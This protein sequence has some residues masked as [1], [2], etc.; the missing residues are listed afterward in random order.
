MD[1]SNKIASSNLSCF[2]L[3]YLR[4]TFTLYELRKLLS[5]TLLGFLSG[6]LLI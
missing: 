2:P 4:D 5:S 6:L 3:R 1:V